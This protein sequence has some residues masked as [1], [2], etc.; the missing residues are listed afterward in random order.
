MRRLFQFSENTFL[1]MSYEQQHKKCSEILREIYCHR[2]RQELHEEYRKICAWMGMAPVPLET[3]ILEQQFHEHIRLSGRSL[4]EHDFLNN[5]IIG[6]K[7]IAG[8]WLEIHSY[9]DGLRSCHNVGSILRTSEAFRLGPVHFSGDMMAPDHRQVQKTSMGTWE[10]VETSHGR[11]LHRLPRPWIAIETV[12]GATP[13]NDWIYPKPCT[14]FVGN[15]ERGISASVL[16]QCDVVITI[17][18]T[19][20]KNSLNVANAFAI[21]ASEIASQHRE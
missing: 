16:G 20:H 18:L 4:S 19:G 9:L 1:A 21:I 3:E 6:D 2:G 13:Y 15:E 10:Y 8:K 12:H 7:D 11:A 14:L 17:P 5:M